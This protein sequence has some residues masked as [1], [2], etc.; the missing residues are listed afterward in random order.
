MKII[1]F[2]AG[3]TVKGGVSTVINNYYKQWN[4]DQ[5]KLTYIAT[6]KDGSFVLKLLVGII[7]YIKALI[8]IP[9]N[10]I[11]HIHMSSDN[12]FFRKRHFIRLA[13]AYH[14]KVII[15]LHGSE[16][17]TFYHK[18]SNDSDRQ[19]IREVFD[20]VDQIIALSL[21]WKNDIGT[22]TKT[23]VV[24]IHNAVEIPKHFDKKM[25]N[26]ICFLGRIG[27]R[28]GIFDLLKV[29]EK[30][31]RNYDNFTLKVGGDGE[32]DLLKQII[33]EK[34]LKNVQYVG[35]IGGSEKDEF[36]QNTGIYALPSYNEGLPMALLEA[37]SFGCIPISTEVGGIPEVIEN[38]VNG[39]LCKPGDVEALYDIFDKILSGKVDGSI[40]SNNAYETIRNS[41]SLEVSLT[42]LYAIYD[43]LV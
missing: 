31:N 35:W 40:I 30:L 21:S 28:K 24:V 43:L 8:L 11:V 13:K 39:Y 26:D 6:M 42:K 2:G 12:S 41:Y 29:V 22:F 37:M 33:K 17:M 38:E 3:R 36:L 20:S 27:E 34:D 14:K 23:P 5:Y 1:M 16:F 18:R 10:D 15:H 4:D 32:V 9:K 25:N 7:A 19:K